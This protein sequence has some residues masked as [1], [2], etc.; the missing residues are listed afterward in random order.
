MTATFF[1][2]AVSM[3]A[4]TRWPSTR[5]CT[6]RASPEGDSS[7][8][9]STGFSKNAS[10]GMAA[11]SPAAGAASADAHASGQAAAKATSRNLFF[12]LRGLPAAGLD[13]PRLISRRPLD[14]RACPRR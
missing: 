6:A 13:G 1:I 14:V 3:I 7:G 8:S 11:G 4:S 2:V 10:T 9:H 12:M 5:I